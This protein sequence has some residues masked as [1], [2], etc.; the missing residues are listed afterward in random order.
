LFLIIFLLEVTNGFSQ[1]SL[2]KIPYPVNTEDLDEICPVVSYDESTLFF[3]RVADY[4]CER[5]LFI[6]S[7]NVHLTLNEAQYLEKLQYVYNQLASSPIKEPLKSGYNQDIW[8]SK[9]KN[10]QTEGIYHPGYPINDVL[11]NSICSNYGK[12]NTFL[13][14]N[15]FDPHGGIERGFSVAEKHG[16]DFTF[17]TPIKIKDF[18]KISSE[19]NITASLDSFVLILA[20]AEGGNMDLY[21]SFRLEPNLYS[22]PVNMGS[23][24]NTEFRESTPML[25]P[26]TKRLFFTSDRPGGYGGKDIYYV[27]RIGPTF[28]SWSAPIKL[29]PPVNSLYDDSHPHIMNDN[30]FIF[31]SSNRDGT[32]DIYQAKLL[33]QKIDKDLTITVHIINGDT[34]EKSPGELIWGDA[35]QEERPGYFR[36]KDGLC[37]Y[38]FFENKPVSFK[39]IN[40]NMQSAEIILDPQELMNDG[41]Y[42]K[43]LELVMYSDGRIFVE[44]KPTNLIQ[45]LPEKLSEEDI[46]KTILINNIYFERTKPTVLPESY[47]ALQKL[48][49]VLLSRPKLYITIIGHTDNVGDPEALKKLSE[50]R[51][52]AIKTILIAEGVPDSRVTTYGYGGAKPIAPNDTEENKSKNRRVEIKIVSQ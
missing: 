51:A 28:Y 42:A 32:S 9:L 1:H 27:D 29:S 25:T 45:N 26:D 44:K 19:I 21:I 41:I 7:V 36:S 2:V 35:Y 20:M 33:R 4:Q 46:N 16:N 3:T 31:F 30:N 5:T 22:V 38:K 49:N 47:P 48:S 15:Q 17:P 39:A 34:G 10:G 11:P 12:T 6:D 52:D 43:T 13:V 23:D 50:D 24:V 8:Y 37:K 18:N 40:R 14:I